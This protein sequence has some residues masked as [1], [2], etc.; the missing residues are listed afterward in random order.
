M[1]AEGLAPLGQATGYEF[2]FLLRGN[3]RKVDGN[4][5]TLGGE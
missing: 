1:A 2:N 5:L 4:T 3:S